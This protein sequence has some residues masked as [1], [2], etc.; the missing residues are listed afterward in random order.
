MNSFG[1]KERDKLDNE[2]LKPGW[3]EKAL[4]VDIKILVVL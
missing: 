2:L 3:Y 4:M 1:I